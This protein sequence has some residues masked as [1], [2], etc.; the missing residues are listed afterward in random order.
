MVCSK[1]LRTPKR[2]EL[3][4]GKESEKRGYDIVQILFFCTMIIV[5]RESF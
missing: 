4:S 5:S 2:Q 3:L 1:M